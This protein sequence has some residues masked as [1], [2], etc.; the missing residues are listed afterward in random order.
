[1][2]RVL[3]VLAAAVAWWLFAERVDVRRR[4]HLACA[5]AVMVPIR[6]ELALSR[7]ER[8]VLEWPKFPPPAPWWRRLLLAG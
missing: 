1:M 3:A 7:G 4:F 2:R 8:P 5:D 6:Y